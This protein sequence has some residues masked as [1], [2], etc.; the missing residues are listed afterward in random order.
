MRYPLYI[1]IFVCGVSV[2]A[3]ETDI[4]KKQI[5]AA[6]ETYD[7]QKEFAGKQFVVAI[8]IQIQ[9]FAKRGDLTTVN[10][11][12]Q[13]L[14]QFQTTGYLKPPA[15]ETLR[16]AY[17]QWMR[18]VSAAKRSILETYDKA[19]KLYTQQRKYDLANELAREKQLLLK[20]V[21]IKSVTLPDGCV[22]YYTF[23]TDTRFKQ[24]EDVYLSDLSGHE[25][26]IRL[27]GGEHAEGGVDQEAIQFDGVDDYGIITGRAV[28]ETYAISVW[29]K[30][31]MT[32]RGAFFSDGHQAKTNLWGR[33]SLL[34]AKSGQLQ[35]TGGYAN[36]RY[37]FID[38]PNFVNDEKWH[39]IALNVNTKED[40]PVSELYI[41]GKLIT[42]SDQYADKLTFSGG[43]SKENRTEIGGRSVR[44]M[45]YKG[46]LDEL[47]ILSRMMK[48]DEVEAIWNKRPESEK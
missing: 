12:K 47:M 37:Q 19:I 34:I 8:N 45:F 42:R 14:Q 38:S 21:S 46:Q 33:P 3:G 26:H 32:D 27:V 30:T 1:L 9:T 15:V 23:D 48:P 7:T 40:P 4:I 6:R 16:P 28:F 20:G 44:K 11:L 18:K 2:C 36:R 25:H 17:R 5:D 29:I 31:N 22:G 10:Q 35:S 39:H 43:A 13:L 24:Q 41:D